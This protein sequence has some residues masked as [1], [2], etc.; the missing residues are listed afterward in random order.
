M[1]SPGSAHKTQW[2]L[3]V[4][5]L[6]LALDR[7]TCA[8]AGHRALGTAPQRR[9]TGLPPEQ[10][11]PLLAPR[12]WRRKRPYGIVHRSLR[13]CRWK[14]QASWAEIKLAA[15]V[16]TSHST[17]KRSG[18]PGSIRP[19]LICPGTLYSLTGF[20]RALEVPPCQLTGEGPR[21]SLRCPRRCRHL[22][23]F[24]GLGAPDPCGR[25]G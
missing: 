23:G 15:N 18:S 16:L 21:P 3:G 5:A 2:P 4:G 24:L 1:S 19:W 22:P 20:A 17:M 11:Q 6:E 9:C 10:G 13:L 25:S 8:E 14:E 7:Y 12:R